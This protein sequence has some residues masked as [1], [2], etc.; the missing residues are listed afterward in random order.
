MDINLFS[1]VL[2]GFYPGAMH[3]IIQADVRE[4]DKKCVAPFRNIGQ[5][6]H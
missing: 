5:K 1:G 6:E 2:V 3:L 4:L